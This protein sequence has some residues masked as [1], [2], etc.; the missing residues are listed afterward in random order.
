[1][2][3]FNNLNQILLSICFFMLQSCSSLFSQ[4]ISIIGQILDGKT[5]EPLPFVS[6]Y[7]DHS[8]QITTSDFN[9]NFY[10]HNISL[11]D[12]IKTIYL[13]YKS[14]EFKVTKDSNFTILLVQ[15]LNYLN[16]VTV[17]SKKTKYK[18][19]QNPALEIINKTIENK[20]INEFSINNLHEFK[21]YE[22][23]KF[24]IVPLSE[25]FLKRK[26]IR[27][28]KQL[29]SYTDSS[30]NELSLPIYI[31]ETFKTKSINTFND[32]ILEITDS[33]RLATIDNLNKSFDLT[34]YMNQLYQ[35]INLYKVN[36][37]LFDHEYTSP[38][39]SIGTLLYKYY[40]MDTL[41]INNIK[42]VKI[43]FVP[44]LSSDFLFQGYLYIA[45]DSTYALI[46]NYLTFN[47]NINLNWITHFDLE[48]TF[49]KLYN[50]KYIMNSEIMNLKFKTT[51]IDLPITAKKFT[52][53]YQYINRSPS[54]NIDSSQNISKSILDVQDSI[55]I[56]K[57]SS[58]NSKIF[59]T[60][61]SIKNS[62]S[63]RN[64]MKIIQLS[65]TG[66]YPLNY[67][68]IG[69]IFSS[70]SL[71]PIEKIKFNLG[72]RTTY[73]F[74]K[75][76]RFEGSLAYGLKDNKLKYN[77][78]STLS[79]NHKNVLL[80]PKKSL[81]LIYINDLF[82]FGQ[83]VLTPSKSNVLLS[84]ERT[85][86]D[87]WI[88]NKLIKFEYNQEFKNHFSY[89]VGLT[90][91]IIIPLSS[92]HFN[93]KNYN[94]IIEDF[95]N[96]NSTDA[97]IELKF[98]PN[99]KFYQGP[100][101][102]YR[103]KS[104]APVFTIQCT[105]N[106]INNINL[107]SNYVKLNLNVIKRFNLFKFGK[108]D[109]NSEFGKSFGRINFPYLYIPPA[110]QTYF[111]D[112][113]G[114]NLMNYLEFVNDQYLQILIDHQLEGF[115]LNK[116]PYVRK[117][118]LRE[119]INFKILFGSLSSTNNP[120]SNSNLFKFPTNNSDVPITYSLNKSPY[121]EGSIG[122]GNIFRVLRIDL[123]KRFTYLDHKNIASIGLR[124]KINFQF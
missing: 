117:L 27:P 72:F 120:S 2:P 90:N 86:N 11:N 85:K 74:Y 110:N 80:F 102:R 53:R 96:I 7:I 88:Y 49:V 25:K 106:L 63:Y 109:F 71:N 103:L 24:N 31:K 97:L 41:Y 112:I 50:Q 6:I 29:I 37:H 99:E 10:L 114:F 44:V 78:N 59:T 119:F 30:K 111:N 65:I 121:I 58:E 38:L 23:I 22:K 55:N 13:G 32:S 48:Q 35:Q 40:I 20:S 107:Q 66:F 57:L 52:Q 84:F 75:L 87:F 19:K 81:S 116:I 82:I 92:L 3:N 8:N 113:S 95:P 36:I 51:M 94:N 33:I 16:E 83:S 46:K 28:F 79:L 39:S 12:K 21:T 9:G 77:L 93:T 45:L 73:K 98:S 68:E 76:L 122:I 101:T 15:D 123:V 4:S 118:K 100:N 61:D 18:R 47:K 1:M 60:F 34:I 64:L 26:E 104:Y 42:S 17:T 43:G 54:T 70:I 5:K 108:L 91:S 67:I 105:Y 14:F 56:S 89:K 124:A 69:S 115:S 62:T